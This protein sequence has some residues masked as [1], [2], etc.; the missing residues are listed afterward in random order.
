[1]LKEAFPGYE[2]PLSAQEMAKYLVRFALEDGLYFNGKV[3]NVVFKHT[4]VDFMTPLMF[5]FSR[6]IGILK[7]IKIF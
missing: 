2:A 5:S 4:F 3:L 6:L 7:K 1:M